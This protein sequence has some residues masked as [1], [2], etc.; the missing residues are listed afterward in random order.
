M[1]VMKLDE[2]PETF[3]VQGPDGPWRVAMTWGQSL[4]LA[5]QE[6]ELVS[7]LVKDYPVDGT[8]KEQL[9]C[10]GRA[11][12]AYA[13]QAQGVAVAESSAM[14]AF[15]P[16]GLDEAQSQVVF[17]DKSAVVSVEGVWK[18][19]VPLVLVASA[20]E[21]FT[22]VPAPTGNVSMINPMTDRTLLESLRDVGLIS[23]FDLDEEHG[24]A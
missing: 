19:P 6:R 24:A 8:E 17:E 14:G 1:G 4:Y 5:T 23:L 15:D 18:S 13:L 10:R 9:L 22:A 11:A 12:A 20:Y 7:A 21:P 2:I 16:D 3:P